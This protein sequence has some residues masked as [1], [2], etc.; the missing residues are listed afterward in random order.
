MGTRLAV[1]GVERPCVEHVRSER[2]ELYTHF[3]VSKVGPAGERHPAKSAVSVHHKR[4]ELAEALDNLKETQAQGALNIAQDTFERANS[5]KKLTSIPSSESR[6][7][8]G[9]RR[10]WLGGWIAKGRSTGEDGARKNWLGWL[11]Q[12]GTGEFGSGVRRTWV[13]IGEVEGGGRECVDSTWRHLA[14]EE[15]NMRGVDGLGNWIVILEAVTIEEDIT[16][17]ELAPAKSGVISRYYPQGSYQLFMV[18]GD[19]DRDE[20]DALSKGFFVTL[21]GLRCELALPEIKGSLDADEDIGVDEVVSSAIDGVF[22]IGES[23]VESMEVHSKFG[24]FSKNKESVEEVV[25]VGGER[26]GL[27]RMSRIEVLEGRDVSSE[28]LVVFMKWV[29]HEKS[30]GVFSVTPWATEGRR[31]VLC[32]VQGSGRRKRKKSV[33]CDSGRQD[34]ALFGASVF[35][36]FNP[37]PGCFSYKYKISTFSTIRIFHFL[38]NEDIGE[39]AQVCLPPKE[40]V[41]SL[42]LYNCM[43]TSISSGVALTKLAGG[44]SSLALAITELSNLLFVTVLIPLIMGKVLR[45]YVKGAKNIVDSNLVMIV[46]GDV[47]HTFPDDMVGRWPK[48]ARP[49]SLPTSLEIL[50]QLGSQSEISGGSGSESGSGRGGDDQRGGDEDADGDDDI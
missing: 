24:E 14:R 40:F 6:K 34:C 30:R 32:Y 26:V 5:L 19:S 31:R 39:A 15:S 3:I 8:S 1:Y 38:R 12:V 33:G 35:A 13:A 46:G 20:E 48:K 44:N 10:V 42:A 2:R 7:R 37:S 4:C 27:A 17:Q 9:L 11:G 36:L 47:A 29:Y 21:M 50:R 28:S 16:S 43:P 45:D 23:N 22:D 41:T 25:V 18:S 49:P